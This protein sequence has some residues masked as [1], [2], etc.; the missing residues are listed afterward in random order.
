MTTSAFLDLGKGAMCW[1]CVTRAAKAPTSLELAT[2]EELIAEL[3][4]RDTFRGTI[5][6]QQ[7]SY[8]GT[9]EEIS[10]ETHWNWHAR[11]C[12]PLEVIQKMLPMI[13][14]HGEQK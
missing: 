3:L 5:L 8:R 10:G 12:D 2:T 4:R 14:A 13:Q 6:C 9:P 7:G 11:N 1:D